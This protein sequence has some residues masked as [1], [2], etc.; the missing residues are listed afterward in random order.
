MRY[1]KWTI[2]TAIARVREKLNLQGKKCQHHMYDIN[3]EAGALYRDVN[4][5]ERCAIGWLVPRSKLRKMKPNTG[6]TSTQNAAEEQ[7]GDL[8][9]DF[10]ADLVHSHDFPK[11]GENWLTEMNQRLDQVEQEW[12]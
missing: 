2:K 10:L 5:C 7:L 8:P 9:T 3:T 4:A 11:R 6:A 1:G 12:A